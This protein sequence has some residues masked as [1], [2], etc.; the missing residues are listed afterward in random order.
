MAA[1]DHAAMAEFYDQTSALVFGLALRIVREHAAAEDI[2]IDVY[3]QVWQ[4]AARYDAVRGSALTWLLTMTRSRAVDVCRARRRDLATESLDAADGACC[5]RPSPE[6]ASAAAE[7]HACRRLLPR[8]GRHDP[9]R[10]SDDARLRVR[11]HRQRARRADRLSR[12]PSKAP[13]PAYP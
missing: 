3:A 10:E 6:A 8:R 11:R 2:A 7:R 1:G 9:R 12:A 5:G 13:A 4:Q